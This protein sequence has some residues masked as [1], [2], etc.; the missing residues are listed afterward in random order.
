MAYW[1]SFTLPEVT[2]T[3][4]SFTKQPNSIWDIFSVSFNTTELK[5]SIA[6]ATF[7]NQQGRPIVT[8][9]WPIQIKVIAGLQRG[10][11]KVYPPGTLLIQK[12]P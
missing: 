2:D 1:F 6:L 3:L 9:Q 8:I 7:T 4:S 12:N 5:L 11:D 10:G